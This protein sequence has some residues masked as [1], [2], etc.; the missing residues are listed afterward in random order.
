MLMQVGSTVLGGEEC[1]KHNLDAIKT[2]SIYGRDG[3]LRDRLYFFIS[4]VDRGIYKSI[5]RLYA[6]SIYTML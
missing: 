6:L 4:E 1:S 5:G 3:L 2:T